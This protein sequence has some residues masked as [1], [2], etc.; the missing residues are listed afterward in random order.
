MGKNCDIF[1][2]FCLFFHLWKQAKRFFLNNLLTH[3]ISTLC[4]E[5]I[6]KFKIA[7]KKT[8][9]LLVWFRKCFLYIK[10]F[11]TWDSGAHKRLKFPSSSKVHTNTKKTLEKYNLIFFFFLTCLSGL[12]VIT[13]LFTFKEITN[14]DVEMNCKRSLICTSYTDRRFNINSSKQVSDTKTFFYIASTF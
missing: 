1:Q 4:S 13:A 7:W 12:S 5:H 8:W 6:R 3:K 2:V 11:I 10:L 9:M 14:N